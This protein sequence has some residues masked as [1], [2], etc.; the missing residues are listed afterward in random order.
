MEDENNIEVEI[1]ETE[2]EEIE[3]VDSLKK[4]LEEEKAKAEKYL[5]NWQRAEAD[6]NNYKKRVE[7]EKSETAQFANMVLILN[8]LPILD[9]F[10]RAFSTL[11]G[12]LAQ[13]TWIDGVRL[14]YRKL[15]ATLEAQGVSEIKTVGEKFDPAIH[16]AVSQKEGKEG[17]IIDEIQKG[18]KLRDRLIRPALVIVG[19]GKEGEGEQQLSESMEQGG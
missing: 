9:D 6:F 12:K 3:D 5:S 19:N 18:Y 7:Q 10:E 17:Q 13:L 15:R 14:I 4:D 16:E 11:A 8:L 1:K 2:V